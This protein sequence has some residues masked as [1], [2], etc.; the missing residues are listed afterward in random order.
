MPQHLLKKGIR[1]RK[2]KVQRVVPRARHS[3]DQPWAL[4]DQ[5]PCDTHSRALLMSTA[6]IWTPGCW[7]ISS[8]FGSCQLWSYA[9]KAPK[10]GSGE[11]TPGHQTTV[12]TFLLLL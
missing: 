8:R 11:A 12:E 5:E 7:P 2:T 3:S 9:E 1:T 6:S 10:A 4:A